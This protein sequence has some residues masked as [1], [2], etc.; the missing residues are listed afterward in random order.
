M[1]DNENKIVQ[2]VLED[3]GP[4]NFSVKEEANSDCVELEPLL[5]KDNSYYEGKWKNRKLQGFGKRQYDDGSIYEGLWVKNKKHGHGRMIYSNG[6][7]YEGDWKNN[8]KHGY[9]V[10]KYE[11]GG[12]ASGTWKYDLLNGIAIRI[13]VFG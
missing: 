12:S 1:A 4:Y 10:Y 11:D 2:K 9:G 7:S 6:D 13:D 8:K 5:L 3:L